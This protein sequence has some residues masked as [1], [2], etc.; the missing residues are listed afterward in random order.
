MD[1]GGVQCIKMKILRRRRKKKSLSLQE[2]KSG[3]RME[4]RMEEDGCGGKSLQ[5]QTTLCNE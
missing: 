2:K 5:L 1:D 3:W 4:W